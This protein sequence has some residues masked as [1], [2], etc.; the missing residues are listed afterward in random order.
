MGSG[1]SSYS[2][3][4]KMLIVK[5]VEVTNIDLIEIIWFDNE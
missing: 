2:A 1:A 4:D 5:Q 3:E